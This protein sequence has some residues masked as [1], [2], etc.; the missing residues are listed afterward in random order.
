MS[1][2]RPTGDKGGVE[3]GGSPAHILLFED[4]ETLAGLLARVLR[5]EGYHVDVLYG[6]NIA[7]PPVRNHEPLEG[8]R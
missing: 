8:A 7:P 6:D 1:E 4:D 2:E 3:A 5:T